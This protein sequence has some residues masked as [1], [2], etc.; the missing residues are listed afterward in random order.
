[1]AKAIKQSKKILQKGMSIV[2]FPVSTRTFFQSHHTRLQAQVLESCS[3]FLIQS[4][5]R[6]QIDSVN[7]HHLSLN[8]NYFHF[9]LLIVLHEAARRACACLLGTY[10][11][12]D[13]NVDAVAEALLDCSDVLPMS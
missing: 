12:E 4:T 2:I 5:Y 3:M 11:P 6:V 9:K 10:E 7:M 1:M 8:L 13:A